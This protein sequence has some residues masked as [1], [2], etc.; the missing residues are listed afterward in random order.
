MDS[1]RFRVQRRHALYGQRGQVAYGFE[2]IATVA[3]LKKQSAA[4]AEPELIRRDQASG[5]FA[6]PSERLA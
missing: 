2:R 5:P 1:Q 3:E 4:A 6:R